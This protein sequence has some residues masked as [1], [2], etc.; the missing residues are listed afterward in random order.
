MEPREQD[1]EERH[2]EG[3]HKRQECGDS[4]AFEARRARQSDAEK[5]PNEKQVLEPGEIKSYEIELDEHAFAYFHVLD[6]KWVVEPG[7]YEIRIGASSRDIR[8]SGT[9][10][11][12]GNPL[13]NPYDEITNAAYWDGAVQEITSAVFSKLLGRPLPE[14]YWD[15]KA[16]LGLNDTIL[17]A[18]YKSFPGRLIN[19]LISAVRQYYLLRNDPLSASNILFARSLT[20]RQ[21]YRFYGG[22]ITKSALENYL[23]LINHGFV[24]GAAILIKNLFQKGVKK[25]Q[26]NV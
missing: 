2:L 11:L 26:L 18:K 23:V 17:Q 12:P 15:R 4:E 3:N 10:T 25:E 19:G 5:E 20:F 14:A 24:K 13:K 22:R 9:I 16:D 8:L 21:V 7:D 1:E 6:K